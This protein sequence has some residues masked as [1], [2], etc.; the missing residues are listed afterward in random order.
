MKTTLDLPS[1]LVREMELRAALE[2]R[3]LRDLA[4]EILRRGLSKNAPSCERSG[5][6]VKLPLIQCHAPTTDPA[7]EQVAEV[8]LKQEVEW[9]DEVARR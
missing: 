3:N 4:M 1:D 5:Q 7:P 2:G 6:R 8:L 9:I